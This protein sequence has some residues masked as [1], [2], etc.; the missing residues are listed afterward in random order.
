M[1]SRR[2]AGA[3]WARRHQ[4]R[5]H[6]IFSGRDLPANNTTAE[7][8]P[9]AVDAWEA[10]AEHLHHHDLYCEELIPETVR[11]VWYGAGDAA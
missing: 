2:A 1:I 4:A 5:V 10:T 8:S 7:W 11:A 6:K 9:A 3:S